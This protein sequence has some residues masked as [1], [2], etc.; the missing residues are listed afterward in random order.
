MPSK[1][2]LVLAFLAATLT[3]LLLLSYIVFSSYKQERIS[4]LIANT[5][6]V[7]KLITNLHKFNPR[8]VSRIIILKRHFD[9]AG[10]S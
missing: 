8:S 3:G 10:P 4:T 2:R 7:F 9:N 5:N 6:D 1:L